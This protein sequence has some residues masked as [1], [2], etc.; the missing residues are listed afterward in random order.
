MIGIA[1][2]TPLNDTAPDNSDTHLIHEVLNGNE[3]AY[4]QLMGRYWG[5]IYARVYS[6]LNS[7]EDAEEITQDAFT[8]AFQNLHSFRW[9]A[10]FSTW[11]FQI[12]SNL[13]RN[14]FWYW[15]RRRR[16]VS[17]SMDTLINEDGLRVMD[18]I[19]DQSAD[20]E[21]KL[22]WG[23]ILE[24]IDHAM[25]TLPELHRQIMELRLHENLSY[26]AIAEKLNIPVGTV[27]SRLA[28]AREYLLEALDIKEG[29]IQSFYRSRDTQAILKAAS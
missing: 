24:A 10:S 9:E 8:R 13:A 21:Q 12:A 18:C 28:R 15:K 5:R 2:T 17:I 26:E 3:Q 6:L 1:E 14:R 7:I 20:P 25:P 19:T 23:E 11:L 27:K 16:D 29:S 22:K 4:N